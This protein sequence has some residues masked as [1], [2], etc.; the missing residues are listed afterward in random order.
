[1]DRACLDEDLQGRGLSVDGMLSCKVLA[2]ADK[3]AKHKGTRAAVIGSGAI[4]IEAAEA[5]KLNG[6]NFAQ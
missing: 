3:L 4:G 1:M 6:R 2:E 5:L